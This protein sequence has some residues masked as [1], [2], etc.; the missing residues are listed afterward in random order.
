[1][2]QK[3]HVETDSRMASAPAQPGGEVQ[4]RFLAA[5]PRRAAGNDNQLHGLDQG[6]A[7]ELDCLRDEWAPDLLKRAELRAR[8]LGTGADQVLIRWG[9]IDEETYLRRLSR[10]TGIAID[11]LTDYDRRDAALPDDQ[12]VYAAAAGM[13]LLCRNGQFFMAIALRH[14]SARAIC[15][16]RRSINADYRL[17]SDDAL[18]RFLLQQ[19]ASALRKAATQGLRLRHPAMSAAPAIP[20]NG[21]WR[22]RCKRA[23]A[24]VAVA[25]L[26]PLAIPNVWGVL[27]A[28]WF[29]A[30]TVLRLTS[31]AIPR[32]RLPAAERRPDHRLP[33]YSIMVALY[34][35][36][37]SV[38]HLVRALEAFD[39]PREKL[40]IILVVEPDDLQTRAAIAR[41]GARPHLRTLIA[42]AVAPQTKPK[43]LNWALPF[44]RGSFIAV[45]DAEDRPE[46][47]QLRAALDTFFRCGD[48]VACVQ[49]SLCIDNE[50]HSL[51]SRMFAVE[52]AGHFDVMLPGMT[53]MG[54]PL[55]L[56]GSSNHFRTELLRK[57]GG[58]DA[59]NVTEDADLGFR[60]ARFGYRSVAFTS[61][62]FEE[63][64]L[65]LDAWLRQRSRWMKGWLQTWC[66]HMRHP[67]RLWRDAGWS[68]FLAFNI[69]AGG[70]VLTALAY[71]IMLYAVL[72]SAVLHASK[73]SIGWAATLHVAAFAAGCLSSVVLGLVGLMRRRRL[74]DGWILALTPLYWICLSAAAWRAVWQFIWKPY[75]W[76][77]TEHGVA[78]RHTVTAPRSAQPSR[79]HSHR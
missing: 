11:D 12:I 64:P 18:R 29:L 33:T 49:A 59:Y 54:L 30:F 55:P 31:C 34:R 45:F 47:G 67:L 72:V 7:N 26:P 74:R 38:P 78:S 37:S 51:L 13:I 15:R 53:E 39:Y 63:A 75:H 46:P 50:T 66:V 56:G 28:L 32:R 20:A 41:L 35:E 79:R 42:P 6:A 71:P 52:Y 25:L 4:P 44:A 68:G 1:M 16:A 21:P 69:V 9:E 27:L 76:E 2:A 23:T 73:H 65:R 43:A 60:L 36:A 77:K 58:W 24:V 8:E 10:H 22:G 61:T 3:D 57:V 48:D 17:T 40:D 5:R 62:T 70:N 19:N 14:Y